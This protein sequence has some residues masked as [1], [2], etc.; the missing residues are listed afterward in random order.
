MSR[1]YDLTVWGATGFT[2]KLMCQH[3]AQHAPPSLRWSVAGRG[4]DALNRILQS[5]E[6]SPCPPSGVQVGDASDADAMAVIAS[7]A[8]TSAFPKTHTHQAGKN[9]APWRNTH[10]LEWPRSSSKL[11]IQGM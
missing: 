1:Q 3:L 11:G 7:K 9:D 5:L 4:R 8:G 10:V 2:G 6:N